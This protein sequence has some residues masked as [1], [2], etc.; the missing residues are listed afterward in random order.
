LTR[1]LVLYY[2][3]SANR[4]KTRQDR[5]NRYY[6]R[7]CDKGR[8]FY[9]KTKDEAWKRPIEA[10]GVIVV[11]FYTVFAGYQ[12]CQMRHANVLTQEQIKLTQRPN[13]VLAP[14]RDLF[15]GGEDHTTA[16]TSRTLVRYIDVDKTGS[17][18]SVYF[19]AT[20]L[21]YS[22]SH[23]SALWDDV[24]KPERRLMFQGDVL[25]ATSDKL[26]AGL[27]QSIYTNQA[28]GWL[29][30]GAWAWYGEYRTFICREY[31]LPDTS[32]STECSDP[33]SNYAD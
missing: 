25:T 5:S 22:T 26:K 30:V 27:P 4:E 2:R 20:E 18:A 11:V 17:S 12:S 29:Y 1:D 6:H 8:D 31:K 14:R 33:N 13:L 28:P 19:A 3:K 32:N 21:K 16:A 9:E 24:P 7:F 10:I 15:I 23:L